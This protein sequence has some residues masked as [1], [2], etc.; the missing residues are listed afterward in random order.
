MLSLS[1][2][3]FGLATGAIYFS[4]SVTSL[5]ILRFIAGIGG[6]GEYGVGMTILAENF[7]KKNWVELLRLLPLRDKL[8][9]CVQQFCQ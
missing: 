5:Y 8:A 2:L 3:I 7:S 1:I 4:H 9:R 6:G